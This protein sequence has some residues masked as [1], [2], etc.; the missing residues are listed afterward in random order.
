MEYFHLFKEV[1]LEE[2]RAVARMAQR[3]NEKDVDTLHLLFSG[4]IETDGHL[5]FSGIGKSGLVAAKLASTFSSLGR[6]SYFLHPIEALHGDLGRVRKQDV[7]VMLSKSGNTEELIK[8]L[9][10][11]PTAK[12]QIV[13]LLGETKSALAEF[14]GL[15]FDCSVEKEVC[16]NNQ[17]PTTSTTVAMAMGDAMAVIYEKIVGLSKEGFAV[18]HPAGMLGKALKMKVSHLMWSLK[19]CPVVAPETPLREIILVMTS[20][21]LGG[22]L[23]LDNKGSLAGVIVEGDIRRTFTRPN[24]GLESQA[25]E[26]MN[27][28]PIKID[29]EE[30][31]GEALRLMED[32]ERPIGILPVTNQNKVVGLIRL[33]DL[34]REG[35]GRR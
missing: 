19:D 12:T 6:P 35:F 27:K 4:L 7:L 20:K 11:L 31:A 23:V 13:G 3:L 33:H 8:L 22:C 14:C 10:Y 29:H 17:A 2:S 28:T 9:P 21:N 15:V 16:L 30:L 26:I 34:L 1:L 32:R 25:H 18:N 5:F 24:M